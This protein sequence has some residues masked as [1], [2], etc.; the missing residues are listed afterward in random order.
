MTSE[1]HIIWPRRCLPYATFK[2]KSDLD[3]QDHTKKCDLED[4]GRAHLGLVLVFVIT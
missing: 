4:Q 1:Y 3:Y 2:N